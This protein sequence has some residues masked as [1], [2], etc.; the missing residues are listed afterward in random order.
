LIEPY[1]FFSGP[2]Q[3]GTI[4]WAG[5]SK[6]QAPTTVIRVRTT[7]VAKKAA[8]PSGTTEL[9]V[10]GTVRSDTSGVVK[11][12]GPVAALLCRTSGGSFTLVP[13]TSIVIG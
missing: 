11:V 10:N 9:R 2:T 12:G 5:P 13:G 1:P 4:Y 7:V 6:T 8:C 3:T